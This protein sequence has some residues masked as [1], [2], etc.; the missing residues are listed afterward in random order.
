MRVTR[1]AR[2]R[3]IATATLLAVLAGPFVAWQAASG[4]EQLS[5]SADVPTSVAP[6][7]IVVVGD[8][9][10]ARYDDIPGSRYQAWWSIV[11]RHFGTTVTTFAQSGSG[12]LRPGEACTGDT[13]I[14]RHEALAGPAPS[15]F[16]V[17]GGR[18]DWARCDDGLLVRADD[19]EI[20]HAVNRYFDA[21]KTF[22]PASTRVVVLGPP[23]GPLDPENGVRVTGIVAAAAQDHGFAFIG[24]DGLLTA[25]HVH[26]GIHPNLAGS[27]AI[28]ARVIDALE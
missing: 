22:L 18:N 4:D 27:R 6:Q 25:N 19:V 2:R 5:A 21:L 13:F 28:A 16:I 7:G 24:T 26:D 1:T 23:W 14:D 12:F 15:L 9:I 20:A 10:T 8:S 11:G 17:E 3:S